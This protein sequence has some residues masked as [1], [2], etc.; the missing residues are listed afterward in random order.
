MKFKLILITAILIANHTFAQVFDSVAYYPKYKPVQLHH[1]LDVLLKKF[2]EIHPDYFK[3]TPKEIV[4]KRYER[5]KARI[6]KPLTRIDF[7]NLFAPV[8]F[9]VIK[10]G[11]NYV[12]APE[13]DLNQ[14][15]ERGGVFFPLPVSIYHKKLFVN[16]IKAELPYKT[17][18]TGINGIAAKT[19]VNTILSSYNPESVEY[20]ER[21]LSGDFSRLYWFNYGVAKKFTVTY[22]TD[23]GAKNIIIEGRS[24]KQIGKLNGQP[25]QPAKKYLVNYPNYGFYEFPRL[26]IGVIEYRACDDLDNFRPF[27]DSVFTK[28]QTGTYKQLVI[29]ARGNGGGTTRLNQIFYEYLTDK[30][31]AQ[32]AEVDVKVSKASKCDLIKANRK[33]AGWFKWYNYLY[34]PIYIR[35]NTDRKLLLTA[36]NGEIVKTKFEPLKPMANK[37]LFKGEIYLL[38]DCGTYSSAAIFAASFKCY[39]LGTIIGQETGE[40]TCFTGDWVSIVLPNTKL[41]CAISDR[42]F[43]LPCGTCDGHGV[44]P[45]HILDDNNDAMDFVKKKIARNK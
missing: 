45:D 15:V 12:N 6:N 26:S 10:D 11:H 29:D 4:L 40:P 32:Y 42:R 16:S 28:L 18:I 34:Y 7:M 43:V 24:L 38:T 13:D 36:S 17:E 31:I 27:C 23:V 22:T 8:V 25:K 41:E 44:I 19:I 1:D 37:L 21:F 33:Y 3:D 2:E 9:G 30:P 35:Q 39:H 5:L 14:Y 20:E